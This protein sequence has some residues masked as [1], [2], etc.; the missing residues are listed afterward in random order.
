MKLKHDK[1][2]S[3]FAFNCNLRHYTSGSSWGRG[4]DVDDGLAIAELT[5]TNRSHPAATDPEAA[6][7]SDAD[8]SPPGDNMKQG[9]TTRKL[10][11]STSA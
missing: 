8:V 4:F 10:F 7:F 2:V 3:N 5:T 1:L 6:L 11:S 9:L